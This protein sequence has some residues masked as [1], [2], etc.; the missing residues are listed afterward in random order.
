MLWSIKDARRELISKQLHDMAASKNASIVWDDDL[1]EEINYLVEWPTALCGG[2]EESYLALPDAAIITPMKDHQRYFPLVDQD[3]K[4]L[5][6]FLTVR[7][8][9]DHSIEVVQAGNERVL[10]ARLDD[11][12]FFFNED[13]KKPLIDRQDGLTKIVFQEG[14]GNLADKLTLA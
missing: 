10:R 1:L 2:F 14:L 7:N 9:S 5:P 4:L 12:K 11:A 8:G 13:R 3:D 6:M